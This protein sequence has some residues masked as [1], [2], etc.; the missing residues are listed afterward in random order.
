MMR[1]SHLKLLLAAISLSIASATQAQSPTEPPP[2]QH[3]ILSL[4]GKGVQI[5]VCQQQSA[6]SPQWVFQAPEAILFD[7]AGAKVGAHGAGPSWKYQ[8]GSTVKGEVV[9]RSASPDPAA[10][11]WLLLKATSPSGLGILTQVDFI[12]RSDT[13]GGVAPTIGCDAQHLTSVSRV[14]YAA[15]YTFYSARP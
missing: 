4:L 3:V 14:P 5:Y 8:D 7:A 10:I 2:G 9:A 12:R 1:G 6:G 11:P 15:T 13:H